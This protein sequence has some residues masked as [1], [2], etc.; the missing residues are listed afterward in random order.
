MN[1]SL[2]HFINKRTNTTSYIQQLPGFYYIAVRHRNTVETWTS[3]TVNCTGSTALYNF[4]TAASKAFAD[5]QVQ[6]GPGVWAFFTGDINQDE[7][8]DGND[9][10]DYDSDSYNGVN[11]EYKATDMNGDG[12]VDGNDF[13]LFDVNSQAGIG[14]VTP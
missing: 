3:V 10:P 7:Y 8:I 14:V 12:Y 6:V 5:N 13:P 4:T 11:A 9:F 2:F 1:S